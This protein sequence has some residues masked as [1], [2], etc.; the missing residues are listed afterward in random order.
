MFASFSFCFLPLKTP[1][2][3]LITC[4]HHMCVY[5]RENTNYGGGFLSRDV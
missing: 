2:G 4:M 5:V 1:E 3:K